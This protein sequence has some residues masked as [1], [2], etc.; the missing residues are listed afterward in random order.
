MQTKITNNRDNR[1][2]N[3]IRNLQDTREYQELH[4][5]GSFSDYLEIV[6]QHP[7]ITR[8]AFQRIYDMIHSYGTEEYT[9]NKEK[10]IRYKFFD[11]PVN[12]GADAVYGLEKPLMKIVNLFKSAAKGYGTEKRL[13]LSPIS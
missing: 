11:D 6:N 3:L 8:N 1:I 7:E 5:E 2:I 10:L 13:F 12:N 9:E 4:W